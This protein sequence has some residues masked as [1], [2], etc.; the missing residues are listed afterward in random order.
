MAI[1]TEA[2]QRHAACKGPNAELFFPPAS[3]ERKDE[4]LERERVAKSICASCPVVEECLSYAM[5]IREV[6][7]IWGGTT[8]LERRSLAERAS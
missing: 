7:G 3:A 5:R 2:W 4:R 1:V 6:H 8:E